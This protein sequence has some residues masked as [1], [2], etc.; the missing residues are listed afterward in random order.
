MCGISQG[1]FSV[2]LCHRVYVVQEG[3]PKRIE[4]SGLKEKGMCGGAL[5]VR[6]VLGE[7][8]ST[9]AKAPKQL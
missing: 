3:G 9:P 6:F 7:E 8:K 2:R 4:T 1:P 5:V